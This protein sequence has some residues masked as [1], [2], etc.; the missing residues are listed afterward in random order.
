M[1]YGITIRKYNVENGK[2]TAP[3]RENLKR[4]MLTL[5]KKFKRTDKI[6]TE[7]TIEK[8]PCGC[9]YHVHMKVQHEDSNTLL[10]RLSKF[11]GGNGWKEINNLEYPI[12]ECN[13][14][15]GKIKVFRIKNNIRFSRY[16]NKIGLSK[17][18]F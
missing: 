10:N 12:Y 18:L 13:G 14:K 1:N 2:V 7:Y 4:Q 16:I 8:D 9:G 5:H 17:H 6:I 11:I 3:T 15:Y